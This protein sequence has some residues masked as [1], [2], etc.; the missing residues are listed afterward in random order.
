MG[1]FMHLC[2]HTN[3]KSETEVVSLLFV[4]PDTVK[5]Q[6]QLYKLKVTVKKR[7]FLQSIVFS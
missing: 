3:F 4:P 6:K 2:I 5:K 7:M 1:I